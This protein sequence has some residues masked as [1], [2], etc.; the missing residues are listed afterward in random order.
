MQM[1]AQVSSELSIE[2][3]S[4]YNDLSPSCT[5]ATFESAWSAVV[6]QRLTCLECRLP[7]N[8]LLD[9]LFVP[10]DITSRVQ[11]YL[12]FDHCALG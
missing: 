9:P 11:D 8:D 7:D 12:L 2:E 6:D 10:N 5:E 4:E 1:I 3:I